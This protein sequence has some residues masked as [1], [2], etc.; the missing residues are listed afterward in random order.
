M[1]TLS[2]AQ[3]DDRGN[4]VLQLDTESL[5]KAEVEYQRQEPHLETTDDTGTAPITESVPESASVSDSASTSEA[6]PASETANASRTVPVSE[7]VPASDSTVLQRQEALSSLPPY[8]DTKGIMGLA[9]GGSLTVF[10]VVMY[11]MLPVCLND[12]SYDPAQSIT[13]ETENE[14]NHSCYMKHLLPALFSTVTGL[15]LLSRGIVKQMKYTRWK[16]ERSRTVG[17]LVNERSV[18]VAYTSSF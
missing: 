4:T 8:D 10:A 18:F 1:P 15:P 2:A 12:Y 17:F 3:D 13:R 7:P 6:L 11:A 5:Q 16:K 14:H 9:V